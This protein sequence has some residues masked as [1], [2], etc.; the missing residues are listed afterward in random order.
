MNIVSAILLWVILALFGSFFFVTFALFLILAFSK[1]HKLVIIRV[2]VHHLMCFVMLWSFVFVQALTKDEEDLEG[3]VR[4]R[5]RE[6]GLVPMLQMPLT[7][8]MHRIFRSWKSLETMKS[9][10]NTCVTLCP[11]SN[12]F[13]NSECKL[14]V[15]RETLMSKQGQ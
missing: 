2:L 12:D 14:E 15:V 5:L 1:K 6:A 8:R 4:V 3:L 9:V 11:G 13:L 7:M 10:C